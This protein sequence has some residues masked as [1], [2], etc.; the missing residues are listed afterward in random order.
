MKK[1]NSTKER[2]LTF[3]MMIVINGG[4]S[5]WDFLTFLKG[6]ERKKI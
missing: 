6:G 1:S 2:L 3:F 4:I 5:I